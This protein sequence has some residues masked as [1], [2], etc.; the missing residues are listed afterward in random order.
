[1]DTSNIVALALGGISFIISVVGL[2]VTPIINLK[3][4]KLEKRL[5]YRFELFQQI[6]KLWEHTNKKSPDQNELIQIMS[7]IN[8]L[9]QL[10][11]YNSEIETFKELVDLYNQYVQNQDETIKDKLKEKFSEFFSATFHTYRKEIR[12]EKLLLLSGKK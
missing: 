9:I 7:Q 6:V 5:E 12:L 10:Y 4:K 2:I 1:M 11:G 8:K 3:S